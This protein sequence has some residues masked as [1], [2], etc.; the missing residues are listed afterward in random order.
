MAIKEG[1]EQQEEKSRKN[2]RKNKTEKFKKSLLFV[3]NL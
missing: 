1:G 2:R 3:F